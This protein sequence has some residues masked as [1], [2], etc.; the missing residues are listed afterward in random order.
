L[1][2]IQNLQIE[3]DHTTEVFTRRQNI[4]TEDERLHLGEYY[5]RLRAFIA[6][7]RDLAG[8][9]SDTL[10]PG[11]DAELTTLESYR[12]KAQLNVFEETPD[13]SAA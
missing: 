2:N 7:L 10:A 13:D 12:W 4:L 6:T 9:Q 1:F 3:L 11:L 8:D 5:K